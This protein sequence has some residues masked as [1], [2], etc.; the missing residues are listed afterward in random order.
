MMCPP[1]TKSIIRRRA[2]VVLL[3]VAVVGG[4]AAVSGCKSGPGGEQADATDLLTRALDKPIRSADV[5]L[6]G[7]LKIDGLQGFDKP[8]R[9]QASGPYV[10]GKE[11]IPKLDMDVKLGALGQGQSVQTGLLT[12]GDR[13]F[14]K[15]G[16]ELYEQPKA[17]VSRANRELVQSEDRRMG[18]LGLD[19]ASWVRD[20]KMEEEEKVAG[21]NTEHVVV[22]VD[23]RQLLKDLNALAR[24]V[25]DAAGAAT[26]PRPPT[27]TQLDRAAETVKDPTFDIYVGKDDGVVHRMSGNVALSVPKSERSRVDGITGGSLRFS[28]ILTNANGD[29]KVEAPVRSRPISELSKQLGGAVALGRLAGVI[30]GM[31]R[32]Q[33]GSGGARERDQAMQRYKA[34]VDRTSPSDSAGRA[35]CANELR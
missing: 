2:A 35:A 18:L 29:Q 1:P 13:A 21:A 5:T 33:V 31:T 14:L 7:E 24:K 28:M 30:P 25:A 4:A 9:I 34:C 17:D 8:V 20:A 11:T 12:T 26:A 6:D 15:F 16:G 27:E 10:A 22:E 3:A 23:V 32:P 19:P